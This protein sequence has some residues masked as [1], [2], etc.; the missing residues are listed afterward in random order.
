MQVVII[1]NSSFNLILAVQLSQTLLK[2][3]EVD[4]VLSD[5]SDN[6][7][8]IYERKDL[9]KIF[10]RVY[11]VEYSKYV[12]RVYNIIRPKYSLKDMIGEEPICYDEVFFWNPDWFFYN[13]FKYYKT[14]RWSYKLHLYGDAMSA[15]ILD[16]PD[17]HRK[18]KGIY[19]GR[20]GKVLNRIDKYGY[21]YE[22]VEY[23]DY[24]YYIFKPEMFI[25]KT[26]RTLVRI[27]D[28]EDR[29][30]ISILNQVFN[31]SPTKIEQKYI[32]L[33]TARDGYIE[34]KDV[35]EVIC[36]VGHVVGRENVIIKAHPRVDKIVYTNLKIAVLKDEIPWELYWMNEQLE[37]KVIVCTLTSAAILPYILFNKQ[38]QIISATKLVPNTHPNYKMLYK[39]YEKTNQT[40][41]K[42][43]IVE[44]FEELEQELKKTM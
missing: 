12:Q 10:R 11:L 37:D 2:G 24:D 1:V 15:Y 28:L 5:L 33:D 34:E 43:K 29:N 40:T 18:E 22:K 23:L 4:I 30:T 16:S 42:V 17:G 41:N 19:R 20:L 3:K 38:V 9:E 25:N 7:R 31:Y 6:L 14:R 21:H 44:S 39:L 13:L 26:K 32:Y 36:S 27:P 35:L 8:E